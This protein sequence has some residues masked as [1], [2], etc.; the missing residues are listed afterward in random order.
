[1]ESVH[2]FHSDFNDHCDLGFHSYMICF[3]EPEC[4]YQHLDILVAPLPVDFEGVHES[5]SL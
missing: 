1:M 2:T 3:G 4:K 5:Q